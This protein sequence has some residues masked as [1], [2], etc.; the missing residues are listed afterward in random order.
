MCIEEMIHFQSK[1]INLFRT[2]LSLTEQNITF[3]HETIF[4]DVSKVCYSYNLN[5]DKV[6][7]L[8]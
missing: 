3:S 1:A 6:L 5:K 4:K 8:N 2:T 7:S